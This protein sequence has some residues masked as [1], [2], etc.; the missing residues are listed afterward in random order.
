MCQLNGNTK[1][2][3]IKRKTLLE[4]NDVLQQAEQLFAGRITGKFYYAVSRNR[5]KTD[6]ERKLCFEAYPVDPKYL[7]YEQKRAEVFFNE[8]IINDSMYQT[9]MES[10]PEKAA[11]IQE[12]LRK[13]HEEYKETIEKEAPVNEQR[14]EFFNE[15]VDIDLLTISSELVPNVNAGVNSWVVY[16]ALEPMVVFSNDAPLISVER[17]KI[18][19]LDGIL[20]QAEMLLD[21]TVTFKFY[22]AVRLNILK[23]V[24]EWQATVEAYP[25]DSKYLEYDYR[26]N[27]VLRKHDI[28]DEI[29]LNDLCKNNPEKYNP[30]R[31]ELQQLAEEYKDAIEAESAMRKERAEYFKENVSIELRKVTIDDVPGIKPEVN[32]NMWNIY[33]ALEPMVGSG[34][35]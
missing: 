1:H 31:D 4:L 3:I 27:D 32:K 33:N 17:G 5:I 20:Q 26:K 12:R 6:E 19:Q 16:K 11:A 13:L 30:V 2:M 24:P 10:D 21:D 9:L 18:M 29:Q 8:N 34:E 23:T 35:V 28:Q 14:K 22:E 15:D 7:E 25:V